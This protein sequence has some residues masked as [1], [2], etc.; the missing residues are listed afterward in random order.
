M[1]DTLH[2]SD[3]KIIS[4][5]NEDG[6]KFALYSTITRTI[7]SDYFDKIYFDGCVVSKRSTKYIVKNNGKQAVLDIE[8]RSSIIG[9]HDL[10]LYAT[11]ENRSFNIYVV[12]NKK[13]KKKAVFTIDQ[14]EPLTE[15]VDYINIQSTL[16]S[17][18]LLYVFIGS[19]KNA[20][21]NYQQ[22]F[23]QTYSSTIRNSK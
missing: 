14:D 18:N 19:D 17:N 9:W 3:V 23:I 20:S 10:V 11:L 21:G 6:T 12:F 1:N 4:N 5:K 13:T 7:I 8:D 16:L 22:I 15:W 2:N